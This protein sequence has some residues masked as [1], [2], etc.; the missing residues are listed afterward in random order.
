M[1]DLTKATSIFVSVDTYYE[2]IG[3]ELDLE[4]ENKDE[5]K[6]EMN[7]NDCNVPEP[8]ARVKSNH[9][10]SQVI[11]DVNGPIKTR[12]QIQSEVSFTCYT[13]SF[14]PK[15]VNEALLDDSWMNAMHEELEQFSKNDVW[16]LIP[17]PKNVN[18]IRT[19]WI[20]K[21]DRKSVV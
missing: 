9:P 14:E 21:T 1:T 19:K 13:S 15:N 12:R 17:K 4:I 11:G 16:Y 5:D 2:E 8:S 18:V 20:Y 3:K 10:L 7:K 6:V